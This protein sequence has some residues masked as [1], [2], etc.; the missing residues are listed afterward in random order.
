VA[1][2]H[3]YSRSAHRTTIAVAEWTRRTA[4]RFDPTRGVSTML[5]CWDKRISAIC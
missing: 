4:D 3:R 1:A 2:N 5:W